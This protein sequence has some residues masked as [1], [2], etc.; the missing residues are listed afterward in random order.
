MI[1]FFFVYTTFWP[2][3][4]LG[5]L[6][7]TNVS[8]SKLDVVGT[9]SKQFFEIFLNYEVKEKTEEK[10]KKKTGKIMEQQFSTNSIWFFAINQ[11]IFT[12]ETTHF[13]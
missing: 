9:L 2:E 4:N 11:K 12:I 10:L 1:G 5:S 13:Y 8:G 3:G 7:S 6:T